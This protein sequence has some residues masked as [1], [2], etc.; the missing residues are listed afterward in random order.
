[1]SEIQ[2]TVHLSWFRYA[3]LQSYQR[4]RKGIQRHPLWLRFTAVMLDEKQR[5]WKRCAQ[6]GVSERSLAAQPGE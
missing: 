2:R 5:G 6:T 1:M 4:M 3:E